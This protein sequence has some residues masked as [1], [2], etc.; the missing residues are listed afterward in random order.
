MTALFPALLPDELLYS[1]IARYR[2]AMGFASDRAVLAAMFGTATGL[3]VVDLPGRVEALL[4]HLPPGHGYTAE[5]ILQ[6]HTTL[7]YYLRF[8]ARHRAAEAAE[9]LRWR[10]SAGLPD[11]LGIRASTVPS[12]TYLHFCPEC[13]EAD[14]EVHGAAYWHRVHQLP[15]VL[16]CPHHRV[17]LCRSSVRRTQGEGRNVFRSL[18]RN[19]L[20]GARLLQAPNAGATLLAQLA[21]DSWWLLS[22][23]AQ[24]EGLEG[25][26]LRYRRRL[27][28]QGWMRTAKQVRIGD[29]RA[30]FTSAYGAGALASLGCSLD[31]RT[32]EDD[33]LARLLRKPRAS[34]HPLHHLLV[35]RF[36]GLSAAEFFAEGP[37]GF[38]G[39]DP[40]AEPCIPC[41]NPVCEP[42]ARRVELQRAAHAGTIGCERCGFTYRPPQGS[43]G[44]RVVLAYGPVWERRLRA[45]V[46][47]R[48]VSL[49]GAARTLGVD[50]RTL[51]RQAR[52]L[53]AWREEWGTWEK[54]GPATRQAESTRATTRRHRA[55]WLRLRLR[56]PGDGV[57]ALRGRAPATYSHLYRYDRAWLDAH[58]P[59]RPRPVG[60]VARVDWSARDAELRNLAEEAVA[61]MLLEGDRPVQIRVTTVARRMGHASLLAQHLDRLP[62]TAV[63]LSTVT[64]T[65]AA[66]AIRKLRWAAERFAAEGFLPPAWKLIRR[67]AL[68]TSLAIELHEEV[69]R[70]LEHIR[71]TLAHSARAS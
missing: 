37:T 70:A 9:R 47:E 21:A 45:L 18:E 19:G 35:L 59:P 36:L 66:F 51:Q 68:R 6:G 5:T 13:A 26:R 39:D 50:P 34:Q 29:L 25:L 69:E 38:G 40:A 31:T 60:R 14:R 30:A 64:E 23:P 3:A 12:P 46:A 16:I 7:P 52:R 42:R 55:A 24:P 32:G 22:T 49:R 27:E 62:L 57:Q 53:G 65:S 41:P 15:G 44:R 54:V 56:Y 17:P 48:Q 58:R 71:D 11:L 43:G 20:T 67:A 28:A 33:W 10:G 63:Y 61:A 1:A 4:A 2:D 8:V